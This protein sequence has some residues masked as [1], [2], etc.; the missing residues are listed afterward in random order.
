MRAGIGYDIHRLVPTIK[1]SE[2]PLGGITIPCYFK[3]QAHSDGDVLIHALVDAMLGAVALGDIGQHFPD[4]APENSGRKSLEFLKKAK[5]ELANLGF[6]VV[7][8][9][10]NILL[11]EPKLSPFKDQI[12]EKLAMALGLEL[13]SVSVKAKTMEGM[14]PVGERSAIAAHV[15]VMV[16]ST[17][18]NS[19]HQ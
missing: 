19:T 3:V 5:E 1:P 14:G 4:H 17:H 6:Q 8:V 15:I 16:D 7:Q 11:E 9:D 2:I 18:G 12:R 10:S 13:A